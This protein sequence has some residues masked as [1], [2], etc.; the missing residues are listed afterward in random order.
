MLDEHALAPADP[1]P[2]DL[3]GAELTVDATADHIGHDLAG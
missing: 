2:T 3:E 1:A